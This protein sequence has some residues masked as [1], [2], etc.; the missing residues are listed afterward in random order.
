MIP[1][2]LDLFE[3]S[4]LSAIG[5]VVLGSLILLGGTELLIRSLIRTA[6]RFEIS[7][8]LLALFFSGFEFDNVA[9]GLASQFAELQGVGFGL[10]IGNAVSI[11]G[12]VLAAGA[13]LVP[14]TFERELPRD[15]LLVMVAAPL[16]LVPVG[17]VG[18]ITPTMG[19][20]LSLGYVAFFVYIY[21]R[22]RAADRTFFQSEEVM[23]IESEGYEVEEAGGS[24]AAD[25]TGWMSSRVPAFIP[26][27]AYSDWFWV[28]MM[29]VALV[30]VVVGAQI[31]SAGAQGILETY[32]LSG[33]ALGIT[34]VTVLYTLDDLL[35][36]IEPLRL[37]YYDIAVGGIIGS[38]VFFVT[39]NLGLIALVGSIA[40][41]PLTLT[42]Y[43]PV[44]FCFTALSAYWLWR[45]ELTRRKGAVLLG[46]YVLFLV[47]T[48]VSLSAVPVGE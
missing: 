9:F 4:G 46:L 48:T 31:S 17:L 16:V 30:P 35:F 29:F 13:L 22:E 20:L 3:F 42:Y 28:A 41:T 47:F 18:E 23:E 34:L 11:F 32:D 5:A 33:T 39:G 40:V 6:L 25:G 8:F 15:Y 24:A 27:L 36:M 2:P 14:V 44:L 12:L 10:A 7:A 26:G 37:G 1:L 45:G 38:L 19:V 43:F 21:R